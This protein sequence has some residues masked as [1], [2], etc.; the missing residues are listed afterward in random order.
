MVQASLWMSKRRLP[1]GRARDTMAFLWDYP[2]PCH[3]K[4]K[5]EVGTDHPDQPR[6]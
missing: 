3:A 2:K 1:A 4:R 6:Y 5:R